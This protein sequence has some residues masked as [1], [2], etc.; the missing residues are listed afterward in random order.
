MSPRTDPYPHSGE[1]HEPTIPSLF[2]L[3]PGSE[4]LEREAFDMF[5]I[6]F[7]DHPDMS[8][9]LMPEDWVGH[10]LRKDYAVGAI[11]VPVQGSEQRTMTITDETP[12]TIDGACAF[13][14]VAMML[15]SC[16]SAKP[17]LRQSAPT[18][19]PLTTTS[20]FCS[21][22][23][24]RIRRPTACCASAGDGGRD[25]PFQAG[26]GL[27][28]HRHGEAGKQLTF[29]QRCTNVTRMDYAS[30]FFTEL[31]FSLATRSSS[32]SR[33]RSARSGSAC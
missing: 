28:A 11:P 31:A 1:R 10:P 20:G 6:T 29:L 3:W 30:P 18:P 27:P 12:E 32:T 9:V 33:S 17:K 8:R 26:R 19:P 21:T 23:D 7:A 22:W 16:A 13:A 15:R 24:R 4:H 5:G 25:R 2:D 14:S